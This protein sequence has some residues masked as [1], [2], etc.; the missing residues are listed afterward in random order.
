MNSQDYNQQLDTFHRGRTLALAGYVGMLSVAVWF[1]IKTPWDSTPITVLAVV[2]FAAGIVPIL[3]WLR[4]GDT[5]HPLAETLQLTLIPFY[6]FP[7]F[8]D[9]E[10]LRSYTEHTLATAA[11]LVLIFQMS[12]FAGMKFASH[13]FESAKFNGWL[14]RDIIFGKSQQLMQWALTLSTVWLFIS[15]YSH[16]VPS[17]LQGTLRAIFFGIGT[18]S[19][20]IQARMWGAGR[21]DT[22]QKTFVVVNV[23]LQIILSSL[24]LLLVTGLIIVL[25]SIVGYFSTARRIPWVPCLAALLTFTVLHN[26][27]HR[28][29]EI[30]WNEGS[31]ATTLSGTP[32]YL[33]E[34]VSYGLQTKESGDQ[35]GHRTTR[36]SLFQR[37][38][39]LQ[40]VCYA[41]DVVP[42]QLPYFHGS[43]YALIPSQVFPRFLWPGKPSPNDSVKQLSVGLGLLSEEEAETTSIGF[44]LITESYVNF[45][46]YGTALLGL[47]L[48]W[49]LRWLALRTSACGPFSPGGILRIL[50]LAWCLNTETTLA[51]WLS[52]FYQ[53][54][55]AIFVPLVIFHSFWGE[56]D[57]PE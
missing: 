26:G 51:V 44:G 40:I 54:C 1:W 10:P 19:T 43:T 29:R 28:M 39:L 24:G 47:A 2:I 31:Q 35:A 15:C 13:N 56:N 9:H 41:V 57:R 5:A 7:L 12:V 11:M 36:T 52:S 38:S 32:A 48:G 23:I 18:L 34:W 30:Y 16:F 53:A 20:F 27:K 42:Q 6:A 45:G 21:L 4:T 17:G 55:V 3:E 46:Y 33:S 14:D 37:A 22:A 49:V 50:A 25:L 8:F